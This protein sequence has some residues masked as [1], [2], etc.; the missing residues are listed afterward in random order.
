MAARLCPFDSD[1][2]ISKRMRTDDSASLEDA[3]CL[4]LVQACFLC[5][6]FGLE[7][8]IP[9]LRNNDEILR[10]PNSL[11]SVLAAS[12]W[13]SA[14][15]VGR[16][17]LDA[18]AALQLL[19][20]ESNRPVHE[21]VFDVYSS[22]R[23]H[24]STPD[25]EWF[26][27]ELDV[28]VKP[29]KARTTRQMAFAEGLRIMLESG[30]TQTR[31][32]AA[33]LNF[34]SRT[35]NVRCALQNGK[36]LSNQLLTRSPPNLES[37]EIL[38]EHQ[39]SGV[40]FMRKEESRE[41]SDFFHRL[42]V[43]MAEEVFYDWT[44]GVIS[45]VMP[46]AKYRG[47]F[48]LD[49]VG[50]GKTR[51]A[52]Q[53]AKV[54]ADRGRT[55]FVCLKNKIPSIQADA[56]TIEVPM[57]VVNSHD[58][59]FSHVVTLVSFEDLLV[60]ASLQTALKG[61]EFYR[62]VVDD[63]HLLDKD[64]ALGKD[65]TSVAEF[66]KRLS[67]C[68][69][70]CLSSEMCSPLMPADYQCQF[71]RPD[72]EQPLQ[73]PE[74][75]INLALRSS[76]RCGTAFEGLVK[77]APAELRLVQED[78]K[79]CTRTLDIVGMKYAFDTPA[80]HAREHSRDL[81]ALHEYLAGSPG[82]LDEL[83]KSLMTDSNEP[84]ECPVCLDEHMSF[85]STPCNHKFCERCLQQV[86]KSSPRCPLCRAG[87]SGGKL[88][89]HCPPSELQLPHQ[90][91]GKWR[92]MAVVT[93]TLLKNLKSNA[94]EKPMIVV[95]AAKGSASALAQKLQELE[96]LQSAKIVHLSEHHSWLDRQST[97]DSLA[98][99]ECIVVGERAVLD[100]HNFGC[101]D[102]ILSMAP[103]PVHSLGLRNAVN[104]SRGKRALL[105]WD[106]LIKNSI[107]TAST[108]TATE[109]FAWLKAQRNGDTPMQ[110]TLC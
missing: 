73:Q 86:L 46:R 54:T 13:I 91:L 49:A 39:L 11:L 63:S 106:L 43:S 79:L 103:L 44:N 47:G 12:T 89:P 23:P 58:T 18:Y 36:R 85:F 50:M 30:G 78:S 53:L 59:T 22:Y 96:Q 16:V 88:V 3:P 4:P 84:M 92:F 100:T 28:S 31:Q 72:C 81:A 38:H 107:E 110:D 97:I 41:D 33:L 65:Y 21:R 45:T 102:S 10:E 20:E 1:D 37:T 8:R 2:R 5:F 90:F 24:C 71:L 57:A 66:L 34:L 60:Q 64:Y 29:G 69:R 82:A 98:G 62:I 93:T 14:R 15:T 27:F 35:V 51:T 9:S 26:M 70:W 99:Q 17:Q 7:V 95:I 61:V 108:Y 6:V 77:H 25:S 87:L 42:S 104:L 94:I 75:R 67:A 68:C 40:E 19:I 76:T 55:L 52:L 105:I 74:L 56:R 80:S 101:C 48:L 32:N 109:A 83:T